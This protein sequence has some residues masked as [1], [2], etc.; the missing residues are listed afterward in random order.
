VLFISTLP[1]RVEEAAR[2]IKEGVEGAR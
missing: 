2:A 1:D